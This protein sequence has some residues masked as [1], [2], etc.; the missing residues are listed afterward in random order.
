MEM[1][2]VGV[3][4]WI[5][6]DGNSGDF[7]VGDKA[8]FAL[9]FAGDGLRPSASTETVARHLGHGVYDVCARVPF[10]DTNVWV[11]DFGFFAFWEAPPP[12]FAKPGTWVEGESSVGIDP[13]FYLEYL[14]KLTGKP[15]LFYNWHVVSIMRN[16]TP[17]L[18]EVN[19]QGGKTLSR[20]EAK[21]NW[22]SVART[23]AWNDDEGRSSYV[24]TVERHDV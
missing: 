19:A 8:K 16:D 9:E 12:E 6:Q 14:H 23:D 24:L 10:A 2:S 5:V 17:W 13:F 18:A 20:D 3:H 22:T 11:V 21:E 7:A 15:N 4:S 1:L